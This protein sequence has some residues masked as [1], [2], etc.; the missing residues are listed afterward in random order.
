MKKSLALLGS[1]GSVG[2]STLKAIENQNF[3][4]MLLTTKKKF[5]KMSTTS[6]H[7]QCKRCNCRG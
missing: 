3:K 7:T 1:T 6:N 2:S 4:I 5:K